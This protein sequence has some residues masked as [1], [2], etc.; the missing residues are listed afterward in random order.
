[1]KKIKKHD[2]GLLFDYEIENIFTESC[3]EFQTFNDYES[4]S[5]SSSSGKAKIV[6]SSSYYN[7]GI[8]SYPYA[9]QAIFYHNYDEII[10]NFIKIRDIELHKKTNIENSK[11]KQIELLRDA[12]DTPIIEFSFEETKAF[13]EK[14][15]K[16]NPISV[17]YIQ[18]ADKFYEKN[19]RKRMGK[20]RIKIT[21]PKRKD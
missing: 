8:Q 18:E 3:R 7:E 21:I 10:K 9:N 5:F 6:S 13:R 16:P 19:G 17:K 2:N 14:I 12:E 20:G 15:S 11:I 4:K 1:M